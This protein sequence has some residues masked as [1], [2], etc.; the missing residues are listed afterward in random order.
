MIKRPPCLECKHLTYDIPEYTRLRLIH[1]LET[2]FDVKC[3][4][5]ILR[6]HS[7]AIDFLSEPVTT[8]TDREFFANHVENCPHFAPST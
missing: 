7:H 3:E 6:N 2:E 8:D 5:N 4:K 1:D